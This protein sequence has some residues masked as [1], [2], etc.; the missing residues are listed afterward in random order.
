M[1]ALGI[2]PA[3]G[4]RYS[5]TRPPACKSEQQLL[6]ECGLS[7]AE[8]DEPLSSLYKV[9]PAVG[10]CNRKRASSA[11][12]H[13]QRT[14]TASRPRLDVQLDRAPETPPAA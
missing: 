2:D 10:R 14:A 11:A 13:T 12:L 5:Q 4:G 9:D 3:L 8:A 7:V 1:A 6:A